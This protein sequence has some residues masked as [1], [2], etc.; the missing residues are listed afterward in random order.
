MH[1]TLVDDVDVVIES[2]DGS[3]SWANYFR[4][5]GSTGDAILYHYG[6][7]RLHTTSTGKFNVVGTI[8]A[9]GLDI[10]DNSWR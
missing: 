3:N 2:D 5:D 1:Y 7:Q 10:D 4:A 9:D 6:A 8:T